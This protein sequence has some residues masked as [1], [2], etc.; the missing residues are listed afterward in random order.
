MFVLGQTGCCQKKAEVIKE[1]DILPL[2]PDGNSKKQEVAQ[3]KIL[4]VEDNSD[5]QHFLMQI[6]GSLYE[7]RAVSNGEEAL[8]IAREWQP[9]LVLSDIMM[10]VMSGLE[11]CSKLKTEMATSHIPVVLLTAK[12]QKSMWWKD[13]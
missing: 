1:P 9:D 6:F 3:A 2:Q 12:M 7:V 4:V 8:S 11:L 13:C 10:P 5:L